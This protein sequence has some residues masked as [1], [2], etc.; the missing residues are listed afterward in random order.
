MYTFGGIIMKDEEFSSVKPSSIFNSSFIQTGI[1]ILEIEA[2]IITN[3]EI[4]LM[5]KHLPN[6]MPIFLESP[7]IEF[8]PEKDKRAFSMYYR[9]FPYFMEVRDL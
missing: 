9:Q 3:K 6:D 4:D 2:P 1:D 5:N 8:I 7:E